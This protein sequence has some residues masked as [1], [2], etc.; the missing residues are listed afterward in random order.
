MSRTPAVSVIIPCLNAADTLAEAI[1]SALEQTVAPLEVLVIDDGSTDRSI[2]VAESFG[3]NVRVLHNTIGG[4]GA[5]R[6]IGVDAASG[7]YIAF[8]DADDSL[9]PTK[10]E[11]Q[12][13]VLQNNGPHTLVHTGSTIFWSD[14]RMP[15]TQRTGGEQAT[16]R[17]LQ[18]VFERN[19]VC[20][21]SSMLRRDLIVE[22][23][24]YDPDLI[25]TEDFGMSL[26][27]ASCCEFVYLPEPLYRIR[28]HDANL[29]S[30]LCHMAYMHWLAQ[31]RFR[32]RRPEAFA[33]LPETSVRQYMIE[34]VLR[35]VRQAHYA[36]NG[37]NYRRLLELAHR[38][39]PDDPEIRRI[40]QK[41]WIPMQALRAWDRMTTRATTSTAAPATAAE[42]S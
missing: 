28:K 9:D 8:V 1:S 34:P 12:L 5:A 11:K 42:T 20:G 36:R 2:A 33:R 15:P 31:E 37:R 10:H 16:G 7:E 22:L 4:P 29:S 13:A 40:W 23:G 38:L 26:M 18:T 27:A 17:C 32:L 14:N 30:R 6:Q 39:A 19:P 41:R 35:A 3:S 24:N 25:G 21:A